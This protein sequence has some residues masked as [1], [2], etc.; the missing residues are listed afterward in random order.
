MLQY[1]YNFNFELFN[2]NLTGFQYYFVSL[3]INE[4]YNS[5][6]LKQSYG[7]LHDRCP[8]FFSSIPGWCVSF[9]SCLYWS[10]IIL[11]PTVFRLR[12]TQILK[13]IKNNK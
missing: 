12:H 6:F 8:C 3:H 9:I 11:Q 5:I 1:T 13:M 7:V 10:F 4:S 2:K